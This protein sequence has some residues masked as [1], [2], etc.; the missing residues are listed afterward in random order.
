MTFDDAANIGLSRI[1]AEMRR[2]TDD[3][4]QSLENAGDVTAEIVA[5]VRR[6]GRLRLLGMGGSHCVNR[7]AEAVLRGYGHDA[8]AVVASEALYA[9]FPDKAPVT[10]LLTSQSGE[11][12]EIARI[13]DGD[14]LDDTFGLTL[15]ANGRLARTVPSLIGH[16]GAE[17]AF[18][19]TRSLTISLALMAAVAEALGHSQDGVRTVL[20]TSSAVSTE[21]AMATLKDCDGVI[22]C[23]RGALI[24]IAEAGALG[25]LE[26]ARMP[27]FALEGGQFR[28]GPIEALR[29]GMGVVFLRADDETTELFSG[30]AGICAEAGAAPV[31]FDAS[32]RKPLDGCVTLQFPAAAGFAAALATLP[33]LQALL[34]AIAKTRV[35]NVG[36]PIRSQKV[37][38]SE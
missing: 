20:E 35:E 23:A 13:L 30:L 14:D 17:I 21:A 32:G 16:G 5:S 7:T 2:Q 31:M 1:Y 8:V 11:S 37:T 6:T 3:A 27:A 9:P 25:L 15:D 19:A 22:F 12:V 18:A 4:R 28:H 29:P 36:E 26:L 10:R 38:R 34:I 33:C 24:G